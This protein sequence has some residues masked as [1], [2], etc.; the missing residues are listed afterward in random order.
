MS[1]GPILFLD[2]G[3]GGVPYLVSARH[4][5]PQQ[6]Y[7]YLADRAAFP[8]GERSVAELQERLTGLIG[9]AMERF[10]PNAAVLA[11]NTASVAA[12][13]TV[14]ERF[15]LPIVGVVPAVKPAAQRS[16]N[17]RVGVLATNA[18]VRAHYLS[19]LIQSY[20]QGCT[21]I[22]IGAK[23]LVDYVEEEMVYA[24]PERHREVV[25]TVAARVEPYGVDTLVLGCTHF[26]HLF[27]DLQAALGSGIRL[28][29]SV[30]GVTRQLERVTSAED[31]GRGRSAGSARLYMTADGFWRES[32]RRIAERYEIALDGVL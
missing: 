30:E 8:Y 23:E 32:Y 9:E 10:A 25:D 1:D 17:C 31:G 11:C 27:E 18:T 28:V 14:R 16:Q 6:D 19:D 22:P 29:D 2:S 7:V 20:A 4:R 5:M 24:M 26:V 13:S 15:D 12:L 3:I 21:V